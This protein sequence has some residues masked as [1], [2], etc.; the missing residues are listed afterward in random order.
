[1]DRPRPPSLSPLP[2]ITLQDRARALLLAAPALAAVGALDLALGA[3]SS[4]TFA[5]WAGWGLLY[6][7]LA[8]ALARATP[9]W[10]RVLSLSAALIAVGAIGLLESMSGGGGSPYLLVLVAVPFVVVVTDPDARAQGLVVAAAAVAMGG[11]ALLRSPGG[12]VASV[13]FAA[14]TSVIFLFGLL[15][16][17]RAR[18][19]AA[20]VLRLATEHVEALHQLAEAEAAR[21]RAERL[22]AVGVIADGVA[23]EANGPIAVIRTNLAFAQE[24]LGHGRTGEALAALVDAAA[25]A[26]RIRQL[27]G[28]LDHLSAT[29][30]ADQREVDLVE[31][32]R[33]AARQAAA[34]RPSIDVAVV[35]AHLHHPV[36]AH[37]P[38]LVDLLLQLVLAVGPGSVRL[39]I[40]GLDGRVRAAATGPGSTRDDPGRAL[41]L[42]LAQEYVR[43]MGGRLEL[44]GLPCSAAVELP[45]G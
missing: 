12:W 16:V 1:M 5:V 21:E 18:R 25:A 32:A 29:W 3:G 20:A 28:S 36:R 45:A 11:W 4:R 42:A 31:A 7:A 2:A 44:A 35:P 33:E 6:L 43:R 34:H 23:H 37:P 40:D 26:E 9:A 30:R 39:A 24:E 22:A 13:Q 10:E 19:Q 14:G 8:A 38:W 27:I 41:G 17:T 15:H